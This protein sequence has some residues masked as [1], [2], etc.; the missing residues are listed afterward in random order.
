MAYKQ[1]SKL[2]YADASSLRDVSHLTEYESR[3]NAESTFRLGFHTVQGELFLAMPR[4]LTMLGERVLC[5]ERAISEGMRS[6]P[7]VASDAIL[8][9][10]VIDEVVSTNAVEGIPSTRR[11]V[12]EAMDAASRTPVGDKRFRELATLYLSIIDGAVQRFQTPEDIRAIYDEVTSGE[13]AD[14]DAPDGKLF[15]EQ[16]VSVVQGGSR[17]IHGGIE[18]E[19]KILEAISQMIGISESPSMPRLYRGIASHYIFEYI[20]PFYDGN[21]RTGRYLLSLMLSESLSC[22][23]ALS[24]SRVISE[25]RES[26][27]RAFKTVEAPLNCAELTFFVMSMLKLIIQAQGQLDSLFERSAGALGGIDGLL[28]EVS[29]ELGLS[30]H[31]VQVVSMLLHYEVFRLFGDAPLSE[32]ADHMSLKPQMARKHLASLEGKGVVVKFRKRN[33]LSFALAKGFKDQYGIRPLGWA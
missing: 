12:R 13:I 21:G 22:A 27:Y 29:G 31:E 19:S 1:L 8:R 17:V 7:K 32:I 3:F 26:Y 10:L 16:G 6:L 15:R 5:S 9:S 11:Q 30:R 23:T 20:H 28:H 33:P 2:Y 24:L 25:N 14:S 4:E 18:P